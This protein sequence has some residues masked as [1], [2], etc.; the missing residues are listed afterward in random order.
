M[1]EL[2]DIFKVVK[3]DFCNLIDY[4]MRGSTIEILTSIST[5]TDHYVSVFI[6]YKN[7]V[8][9]VSD[10]AWLDKQYYDNIISIEDEDI[11]QRVELQ[12]RNHFGINK[13][14]NKDGTKYNFKTTE[15]PE[16]ISSLVYD[17]SHYVSSVVNSQSV[18]Y[19]E[20]KEQSQRQ[21]FYQEVNGFLK[22]MYGGD[23]SLN[24]T[25]QNYND[26]LGTV[27]FNAIITRPTKI[28]LVMYVT[29]YTPQNFIKDACE[30]TVNFQIASKYTQNDTFSRTAIVNTL[31]N[32]YTPLKV[33][34]YLNNLQEQTNNQLL[35]FY[36]ER[37]NMI[38]FIPPKSYKH[39]IVAL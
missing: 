23:L 9:I 25:L 26:E 27:K 29:G 7:G 36:N 8:Y 28:H 6:S 12:Y 38:R 21:R 2:I 4:K 1:T 11:I 31:A 39:P 3:E 18:A 33:N 32:G 14:L 19:Q 30:A 13:T 20:A 34:E 22:D 24:E 5:I 10:G 37:D 16:L 17:V 35:S 15:N